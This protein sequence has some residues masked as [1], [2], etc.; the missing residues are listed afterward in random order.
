MILATAE[1]HESVVQSLLATNKVDVNYQTEV[2]YFPYLPEYSCL[3]ILQ[4]TGWSALF[5]AYGKSREG[6]M[7]LLLEY[8]ADVHL[9]DR[10]GCITSY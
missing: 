2:F 8:G 4:D 3:L 6:I 1:G 5:F 7:K 9:R 10:V